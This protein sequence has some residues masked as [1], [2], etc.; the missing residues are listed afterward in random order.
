ML[1]IAAAGVVARRQRDERTLTRDQRFR[2]TLAAVGGAILGAILGGGKGAA[3]GGA[4]GAAGGS[5][6]VASGDRNPVT[7]AAGTNLTVRIL[8]PVSIEVEKNEE[9]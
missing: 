6:A 4:I 8:S 3:T 2:L 7:L 1:G 9:R 5:A